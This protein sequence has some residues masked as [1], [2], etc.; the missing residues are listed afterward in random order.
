M[1]K[2]QLLVWEE[3]QQTHP[4][5]TGQG[6]FQALNEKLFNLNDVSIIIEDIFNSGGQ[7]VV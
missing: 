3:F 7:V 1:A 6:D 5:L 2:L 4:N